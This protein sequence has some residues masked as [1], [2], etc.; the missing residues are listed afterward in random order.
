MVETLSASVSQKILR[1]CMLLHSQKRNSDKAKQTECFTSASFMS[2]LFPTS[3]I[4]RDS[5][6]KPVSSI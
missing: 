5:L 6:V 2:G 1:P 3:L 4:D